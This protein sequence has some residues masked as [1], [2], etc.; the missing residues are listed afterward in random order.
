MHELKRTLIATAWIG[1]CLGWVG[2]A[3]Q[4]Q[5]QTAP[6]IPYYSSQLLP[7]DREEIADDERISW[8][9]KKFPPQP[10][11]SELYWQLPPGDTG[12]LS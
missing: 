2:G 6:P 5:A 10:Y 3:T 12:I 1:V 7:T 11:M 8:T 4:S 9:L